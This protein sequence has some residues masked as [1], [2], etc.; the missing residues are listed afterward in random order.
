MSV[1]I[2][3]KEFPP[4]GKAKLKPGMSVP[5]GTTE[6]NPICV[7]ALADERK[8]GEWTSYL[9]SIV[10]ALFYD[11]VYIYCTKVGDSF[12]PMV[13]P[14]E[15]LVFCACMVTDI[16][17]GILTVASTNTFPANVRTIGRTMKCTVLVTPSTSSWRQRNKILW[18]KDDNLELVHVH[19]N[20]V[21]HKNIKNSQWWF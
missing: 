4:K 6:E 10:R 3:G 21:G 16:Q 2:Y 17:I 7:V 19:P 12:N 20:N 14:A 8:Q 18:W 9:E 5:Q 1:Y 15:Q 11:C 13:N